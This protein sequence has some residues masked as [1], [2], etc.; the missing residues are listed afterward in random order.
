MNGE[1][2]IASD[3]GYDNVSKFSNAFREVMGKTPGEYRKF[4]I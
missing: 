4:F 1:T 2:D 3:L